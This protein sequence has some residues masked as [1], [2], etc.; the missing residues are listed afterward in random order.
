VNR[1]INVVVI[2][3]AQISDWLMLRQAFW[4]DSDEDVHLN[5]MNRFLNEPSRYHQVLAMS[6]DKP[7]GFIEGSIRND[8]VNG[9]HESPVGYLEGVYVD[10]EYR[11][12]GIAK[13]LL[14]SL[15]CWFK[16]NQCSEMASDVEI[17]N[18]LSIDVHQALGFEETERVVFFRKQLS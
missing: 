2:S 18:N 3:K 5:E 8:Y 11:S 9:T 4:P 17:R 12:K 1:L 16:E 10:E 15:V 7:I 14:S 13:Q 6:G